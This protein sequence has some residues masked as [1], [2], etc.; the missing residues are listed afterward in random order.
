MGKVFLNYIWK[1]YSSVGRR[2]G[3][4]RLPIPPAMLWCSMP[5]NAPDWCPSCS[6][7]DA[8]FE[9]DLIKDN[10]NSVLYHPC[11]AGTGLA[12]TRSGALPRSAAS[13]HAGQPD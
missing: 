9:R 1:Q 3:T 6:P 10:K 5:D 12:I 8:I 13:Q 11:E 4:V 7:G 2:P